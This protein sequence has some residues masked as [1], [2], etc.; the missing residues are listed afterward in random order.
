MR[1]YD[2]GASYREGW[3]MSQHHVTTRAGEIAEQDPEAHPL[4]HSSR[5]VAA[6]HRTD[7]GANSAARHQ[8]TH[9]QH[10][11]WPV[12]EAGAMNGE[13]SFA[14]NG[15]QHPIGAHEP[16]PGFHE[17]GGSQLG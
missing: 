3:R 10:A 12:I 5:P 9:S 2:S 6:H 11:G 1:Q 7:D 15:K 8:Q 14:E 16:Q 13:D 17:D 4:L